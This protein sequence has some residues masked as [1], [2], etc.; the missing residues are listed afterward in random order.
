[1]GQAADFR[2]TAG[3]SWGRRSPGDWLCLGMLVSWVKGR[4]QEQVPLTGG[5]GSTRTSDDLTISY[6]KL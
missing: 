2:M 5:Y 3:Q 4:T 1:M 6:Y